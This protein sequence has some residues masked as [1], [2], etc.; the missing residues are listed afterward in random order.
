M[1]RAAP[2]RARRCGRPGP[3]SSSGSART[4]GKRAERPHPARCLLR[5]TAARST[6]SGARRICAALRD[7]FDATCTARHRHR[8]RR[9]ARPAW[10]SPHSSRLPRRP[11]RSGETPSCFAAAPTSTR[12]SRTRRSTASIDALSRYLLYRGDDDAPLRPPR[13]HLGARAPVPRPA[14]RTRASRHSPRSHSPTRNAFGAAPSGRCA[15]SSR[16]S[17]GGGRSCSSW[18]TRS[19]ATPTALRWCSSSFVRRTRR[20]SCS[21]MTCRDEEEQASPF[22]SEL[23]AR[24]PRQA[25]VRDLSSDRS[26]SRRRGSSRSGCS[27]RTT[28]RRARWPTRLP[29]SPGEARS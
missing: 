9:R 5:T 3:R 7:A 28:T 23:K 1:P 24:W 20:P 6:S 22:L 12:P 15:S 13:G 21:S 18:T 17:R 26:S 14:A 19:G 27:A 4:A 8:P 29:A 16:R 2:A 11:R 25:E 10:A